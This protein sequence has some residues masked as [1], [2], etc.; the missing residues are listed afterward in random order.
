MGFLMRIYFSWNWWQDD[1]DIVNTFPLEKIPKILWIEQSLQNLMEVFQQWNEYQSMWELQPCKMISTVVT[2]F[3][4]F[5]KGCQIDIYFYCLCRSTWRQNQCK[6]NDHVWRVWKMAFF[7]P[8][9]LFFCL[10]CNSLEFILLI[11]AKNKTILQRGMQ[12]D[13]S[14]T[15]FFLTRCVIVYDRGFF[16]LVYFWFLYDHFGCSASGIRQVVAAVNVALYLHLIQ[17]D[18]AW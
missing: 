18:C 1:F 11:C 4:P 12:T 7:Q 5:R 3:A 9:S 16:F 8:L 17:C 13:F 2:A 6:Y 14:F 15:I 10:Y